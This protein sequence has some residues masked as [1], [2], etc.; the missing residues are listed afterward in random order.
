MSWAAGLEAVVSAIG[1]LLGVALQAAWLYLAWRVVS[2]LMYERGATERNAAQNLRFAIRRLV[3][4]HRRGYAHV[5]DA[6]GRRYTGCVYCGVDV[7]K[8]RRAEDRV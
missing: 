5:Q 6:W 1:L 8:N 3:C 4:R 2:W 7:N